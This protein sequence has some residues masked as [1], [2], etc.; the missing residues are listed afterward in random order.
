MRILLWVP[1][2]T[3]L[4][5]LLVWPADA[6]ALRWGKWQLRL[7]IDLSTGYDNNVR[8][9]ALPP[10]PEG[11]RLGPWL[12]LTEK[13]PT[14]LP[15]VSIEGDGV[16]QVTTQARLRYRSS[17]H[18]WT[19][20]YGI[21]YKHFFLTS[22]EDALS[23]QAKTIYYFRAHRRVL[24]GAQVDAAD[25]RRFNQSREFSNLSG[26]FLFLWFAPLGF[27]LLL[28]GGY[29]AF[30]YR[31]FEDFP[32][33][34]VEGI[35]DGERFSFHGDFYALTLRKRFTRAFRVSA[36][37]QFSRL[38]YRILREEGPTDG[39]CG[40]SSVSP[41]SDYQ[42]RAGVGLR[43]LYG[44][45]FDASYQFEASFSGSCG[46]SYTG[47]RLFFRFAARP[48]WKLYFT[49]QLQLQFRTF[50]SGTT[51]DPNLSSTVDDNLTVFTVRLSR[52]ILPTLR[53]NL[54]YSHFANLLGFGINQYA[55]NLLMAGMSLRF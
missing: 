35:S 21:G 28:N 40:P 4:L 55:R 11:E 23:Q 2:C 46:E 26:R 54:R 52:P 50:L 53:V 20:Q 6:N 9:I 41:R 24:L 37:Y 48:F 31:H 1:I 27:Q 8:R 45:L 19:L 32:D 42:H 47:H 5:G 49:M 44:V 22:D 10:E 7:K 51:F 38:F 3:L 12:R 25:L 36:S 39:V 34:H 14:T 29:G 33:A 17:Q 43:V 15:P 13:V 16:H 18:I 30:Q